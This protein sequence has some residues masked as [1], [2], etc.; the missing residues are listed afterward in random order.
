LTVSAIAWGLLWL[1]VFSMPWEKSLWVPQLGTISHLLGILA[2]C[3]WAAHAAWRRCWRRPNLALVL[4]GMLVCWFAF[5]YVWS[6]D[7]PATLMRIKTFTELLVLVWLIWNECRSE[8]RQRQLL[9][10]YVFGAA[11][12]ALMAIWR[13][14]HHQQ[15][16]YLRYAAPGFDPNDFGLILALSIGPAFYLA[17]RG[18]LR[19]L[20]AAALAA[21][22]PAILL[23]A[24]RTAW[25]ASLVAL[26]FAWAA[27]RNADW[28]Y[29]LTAGA[30]TAALAL[31]PAMLAPAPQR[32][33]LQT[34]PAELHRGT[35]HGRT[36]IWKTGLKALKH[37]LVQGVG[38][39]AYP[40][41]VEPWLGK[42]GV[43]GAQYVAHNTF[44]SVLVETGVIGFTLL[45][46]LGFCLVLFV[47]AMPPLERGLWT[48]ML[49]VWTSGVSTLTW[50]QYK[51]TWL[52][53][54]LIMTEWARSYWTVRQQA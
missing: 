27:W 33:R 24:S 52:M 15:T 9:A 28:S 37:H 4:A 2:F 34:L 41:A 22:I 50:E 23:T 38:S 25:V 16:Y 43:P 54:G 47:A 51:P 12:A 11:V 19:G 20:A 8:T 30:A 48:V 46:F 21:I 17:R 31:G 36:R 42:P 40:K 14:L 1:L 32:A 44:L 39:G 3:A 5:T 45:G 53:I 7:R 26:L 10:A 29:R 18:F 13:Y 49:L 6:L 35:L